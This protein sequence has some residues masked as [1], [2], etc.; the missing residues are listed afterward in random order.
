MR[1]SGGEAVADVLVA[2][3]SPQMLIRTMSDKLPDGGAQLRAQKEAILGR[4]TA[5]KKPV[6]EIDL[7]GATATGPT[8]S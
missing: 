3:A 4:M 7:T 2:G 5:M 8:V 6:P 1:R